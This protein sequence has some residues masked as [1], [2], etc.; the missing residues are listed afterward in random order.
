MS[1]ILKK[2][3]FTSFAKAVIL[4]AGWALLPTIWL[5]ITEY[6]MVGV[7][8]SFAG[9]FLLKW[10]ISTFIL[11]LLDILGSATRD[12]R[13]SPFT[14]VVD[15][16]ALLTAGVLCLWFDW[17][18]VLGGIMVISAFS[19]LYLALEQFLS[20]SCNNL[21]TWLVRS[22][23]S[24]TAA[25]SI[26]LLTQMETRFS[27]E[28]LYAALNVII[29]GVYYG[30][31][32]LCRERIERR[33]R[34]DKLPTQKFKGH[35]WG[36]LVVGF[37]S[38]VFV[39]TQQYQS[40]FNVTGTELYQ[41]ITPENPFLCGEVQPA[42]SMYEGK[43]IFQQLIAQIESRSDP[44]VLE[45]GVL[46]LATSDEKWLML[47][48]ESILEEARMMRFTKPANSVKWT[49]H[50]AAQRIYFAMEINR[51]FP[52]LFSADEQ[53]MLENWFNAINQRAQT[54]EW[55]DWLYAFALRKRPEG[56]YE[57]QEHGAALLSLLELSGWADPSLTENNLDYITR[58][59]RGWD[60]R[61][62]N[63]DDVYAY[64]MEWLENAGH[65]AMIDR[66][67][68]AENAELSY[69]WLL[70]QALPDGAPLVYNYPFALSPASTAYAG[71]YLLENA[72]LLWWAGQLLDYN[73]QHSEYFPQPMAGIQH[74][75]DMVAQSPT[76]GSCLLYGDSG[77]PNQDDGIAPDK[78]IFRDGWA[79]DSRYLLLNLRFSGWHR[80][81]ATNA[82]ML[83]YQQGPLIV[84]MLQGQNFSWMPQGRSIVRDKRVPR[85]N[86]NGLQIT[87]S[88]MS[89]ILQQLTGVGGR[90]AQDP[91]HYAE[92]KRFETGLVQDLAY[93][94]VSDWHG[95]DH[96]RWI[97]FRHNGEPVVV[98]DQARGPGSTQARLTWHP[99]SAQRIAEN[100][101]ILR[102][103]ENP[104]EIV[105]LPFSAGSIAWS[106]D[107]GIVYQ[108]DSK[109]YLG[110]VS[111]FL[112][113]D[114]TGAEI[115]LGQTE[116]SIISAS[117]SID[118][119][120]PEE[121][122]GTE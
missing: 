121:I 112:F 1:H 48:K 36:V 90:W 96:D 24:I 103:G 28:E 51:Q 29:L 13:L 78:I 113:G 5:Q 56:P 122:A 111:V 110:V 70:Y 68:D 79:S 16:C 32:S 44:G 107:T 22:F 62:R 91:P 31:L 81:K 118:I 63:T 114:W 54:A 21:L 59:N 6:M 11:W 105:M 84:E 9:K 83:L 10:F 43:A 23:F 60:A 94:R 30:I 92:V 74:P 104:V 27:Q 53:L 18:E 2:G 42:Q 117:Q 46:S 41:G 75:L 40:S 26:V 12:R 37:V 76:V 87:R 3:Q 45:Y 89:W 38:L 73:N 20:E 120:L 95:W 14:A 86:L 106:E 49:Q 57:N 25:M 93:T 58:E 65:Q 119:P 71:A 88:G 98:I 80:Y 100:R 85:E 4:S 82:V 77:L 47:F 99:D 66:Q 52:S 7:P 50:Q 97:Y 116:L 61:F 8:A 17:S 72:E 115:D 35:V 108:E 69:Q 39:A 33:K 34:I 67:I 55:V 64:Q 101:F 109:G 15:L 19:A 102:E